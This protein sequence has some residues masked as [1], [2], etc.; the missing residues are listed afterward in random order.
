MSE[1]PYIVA[2]Y[3]VTWA[4]LGGYALYLIV[5]GNRASV[6]GREGDAT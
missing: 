3:V 1:L 2:A 4:M 6:G 5:R